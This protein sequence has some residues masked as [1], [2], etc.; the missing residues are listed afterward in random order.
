MKITRSHSWKIFSSKNSF[1][2]IVVV[3]I[4]S[5]SSFYTSF[6]ILF[7]FRLSSSYKKWWWMIFTISHRLESKSITFFIST[8]SVNLL[9]EKFYSISFV[10]DICTAYIFFIFIFI[11]MWKIEINLIDMSRCDFIITKIF[12]IYIIVII[13][14]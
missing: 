3:V 9:L 7:S 6:W 14:F 8:L 13:L 11:I 10:L 12:K 2:L 5:S 1:H 4:I